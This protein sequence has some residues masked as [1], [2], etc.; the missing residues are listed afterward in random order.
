MTSSDFVLLASIYFTTTTRILLK[1]ILAEMYKSD[2]IIFIKIQISMQLVY[3]CGKYLVGFFFYKGGTLQATCRFNEKLYLIRNYHFYA[4]LPL[5]LGGASRDTLQALVGNTENRSLTPH[6]NHVTVFPRK[7]S[8]P[9]ITVDSLQFL[10]SFAFNIFS[11]FLH[12][13]SLINK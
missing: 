12:N 7:I 4:S 11:I 8:Q 5:P 1:Q 6:T 9:E 2:R 13:F 10:P 3:T